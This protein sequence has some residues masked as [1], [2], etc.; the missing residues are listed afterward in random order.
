[1][2]LGLIGGVGSGKSTVTKILQEEYGFKLLLTD[3]IAKQLELP[4]GSC[5]EAMV[6]ALG[7]DILSY[8]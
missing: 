6:K 2:I 4:G 7:E 3:G 5:Y 8:V 1:M